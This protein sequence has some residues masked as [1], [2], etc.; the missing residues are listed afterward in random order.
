MSEEPIT[1][2]LTIE[3]DERLGKSWR[4]SSNRRRLGLGVA[5]V[6]MFV[7]SLSMVLPFL[8]MVSTSLKSSKMVFTFPP[9]WIPDPIDWAN[10]AEIWS[11]VPLG[12]GL[13]NSTIVTVLVVV[14][15]TFSSTMAA[16]AFAKL[17]FPHKPLVFN[18][19]LASMMIPVVVILVPQFAIYARIG[20]IDTLLPLIV[21]GMLGN[22]M[23]IFFLRQYMMGL[24]TE[25]M[26]AAKIDGAGFLRIYWSIFMPLAKPAVAANVIIV[27]MATWNDYLGPLIY[28]HSPKNSTVQ[29]VIASLTAY[30]EEQTD[31]PI[32]MAASAIA[33]LPVIAIFVAL[34]KHFVNSFA[35]SG[36]KG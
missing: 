3:R 14:I 28:T 18:I 16:F 34:Q 8:W 24:P 27:F 32:I 20:W 11:V 6:A 25:L 22:V 19:L 1:S 2:S 5:F 23:M 31:F 30:Y 13:L 36:I 7:A 15:G 33:V 12:R 10:Y 21:P 9:Q 26:D 4:T 35:V 29:L 17:D